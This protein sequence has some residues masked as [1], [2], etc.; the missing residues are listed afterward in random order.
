M[1]TAKAS[2]LHNGAIG[3]FRPDYTTADPF[4]MVPSADVATQIPLDKLHGHILAK[5][6]ANTVIYVKLAD[7]IGH[8]VECIDSN[9]G[10]VYFPTKEMFTIMSTHWFFKL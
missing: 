3:Q 4:W 1:S 6:Y 9:T 7:L 8:I 2:K 5:L 10:V